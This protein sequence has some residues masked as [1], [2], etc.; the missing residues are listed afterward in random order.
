MTAAFLFLRLFQ[1]KHTE[2]KLASESQ[3][4]T[5]SSLGHFI[6]VSSCDV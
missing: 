6:L 4:L 5:G 3:D 1:L 2:V